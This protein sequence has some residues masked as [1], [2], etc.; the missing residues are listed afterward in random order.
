MCSSDLHLGVDG[1][2]RRCDH[3]IA[4]ELHCILARSDSAINSSAIPAGASGG[5]RRRVPSPVAL[6]G[7]AG[8]PDFSSD[9]LSCTMEPGGAAEG[10]GRSLAV[11]GIVAHG[12][13]NVK[14]RHAAAKGACGPCFAGR[15][16][17]AGNG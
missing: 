13:G 3:D 5:V 11:A 10:E 7:A 4:G 12:A 15:S 14:T 1:I 16:G 6:D 9:E 17:G 2:A 8:G